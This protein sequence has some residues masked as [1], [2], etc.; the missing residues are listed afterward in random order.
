MSFHTATWSGALNAAANDLVDVVRICARSYCHHTLVTLSSQQGVPVVV[1][2]GN[3]PVD[4]CTLTP[5]SAA[6]V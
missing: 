5:A 6:K 2:A 1:A 4:A 3:K